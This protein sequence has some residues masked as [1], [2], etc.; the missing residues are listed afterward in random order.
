MNRI[1]DIVIS[2]IYITALSACSNNDP[3]QLKGSWEIRNPIMPMIFQ[4][5]TGESESMGIIEKVSYKKDGNS[6]IVTSKDGIGKGVSMR[7]III[8][9]NT[10]QAGS[11]LMHRIKP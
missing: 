7:Y 10:L 5:R 6:V 9:K 8:D 3:G 11:G 2:I 4:F 1:K